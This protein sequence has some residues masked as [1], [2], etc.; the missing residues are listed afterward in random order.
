MSN[1]IQL[2]SQHVLG[3]IINDLQS[4]IESS[5]RAIPKDEFLP[6]TDQQ[7]IAYVCHNKKI[8][9]VQLNED[10]TTMTQNETQIGGFG[11]RELIH[12]TGGGDPILGYGTRVKIDIP[13]TGNGAIFQSKPEQCIPSSVFGEVSQYKLHIE[14]VLP[15]DADA[16]A[17]KIEYDKILNEIKR[18]LK[19]ANAQ[20]ASHNRSCDELVVR[21]ANERRLKLHSHAKISEVLNIPIAVSKNAPSLEPQKIDIQPRP[22]LQSIS[23][24]EMSPEP[25]ISDDDYEL[26]LKV[27]GHQGRA[28]EKTPN[29]FAN[30]GEENI[31][32]LVLAQLNVYFVGAATAE[33]FRSSGKT[34]ICIQK[35]DRAA[36]VGE[37]K[38]WSGSESLSRALYQLLRYLTWRD[39]KAALIILNQ[40][41]KS[42][43]DIENKIST[44]LKEH[45]LFIREI[46]SNEK[47]EWRIE[48][49]DANDRNRR[50]IVHVFLFNLYS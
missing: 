43:T 48:A 5:V 35:D 7:L 29:T 28:F 6:A 18:C 34:D 10:G 2:F 15:D 30:F 19:Y 47:G 3:D 8:E 20:A 1:Q 39:S 21:H 24:V 4:R 16:D 31:R 49:R 27:I 26:I 23:A 42:I 44:A 17:Y 14:I 22:E 11:G 9:P 41:N 45:Q 25:G 32:D 13:F 46:E 40:H 33:T 37:L 36:F 50:V 38:V 12:P